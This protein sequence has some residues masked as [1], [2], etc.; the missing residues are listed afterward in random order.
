MVKLVGPIKFDQTERKLHAQTKGGQPVEVE[1]S[2]FQQMVAAI[3]Q[4]GKLPLDRPDGMWVIQEFQIGERDGAV[5]FTFRVQ[6]DKWGTFA[7]RID[8]EKTADQ[9]MKTLMQIR[10]LLASLAGI[11][12]Q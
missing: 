12:F 8:P 7:M 5:D 1:A 11:R 9:R 3:T 10:D 2:V 6:G 4:D